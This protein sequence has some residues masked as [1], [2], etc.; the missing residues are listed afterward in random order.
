MN[1]QLRAWLFDPIVGKWVAAG[2]VVLA[3]FIVSRLVQRAVAQRVSDATTRYRA[4][5]SVALV[6]YLLSVLAVAVVFSDRLGGLTV[7]FGVAGAGIAFALQEVIASAAGW[8]AISFGRFYEPGDRVQLGGIK[9]DVIDVGM[10]RT[11][12][13]EVGQWVDSD[14]YNGRIVRIANSF[15]F[16]EPVFN[17]S[18]DFPFLWDEIKLPVRYGSDW[19]AAR[20]ML[21]KVTNE[22]CGDYARQ[23]LEAWHVAVRKYA[24]EEAR[25]EPMVTLAA[26]D[27]WLEFTARYIV[28]YRARRMVKDQLFTRILEEVDQSGGNIRLAS[29][30]MEIVNMPAFDVSMPQGTGTIRSRYI[31]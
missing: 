16:K 4:R 29:A 8:V 5:K 20:R 3:V 13:M 6:G 31:P 28:H 26:N 19:K 7:A 9:G 14:L 22:I 11:T 2:T 24:L 15:I 23:S 12:L 10:L 18:A 27:N 21:E 17:Y 30:T 1:D 25:V